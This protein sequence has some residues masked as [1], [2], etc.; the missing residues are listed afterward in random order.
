MTHPRAPKRD[1]PEP[2]KLPDVDDYLTPEQE[3]QLRTSSAWVAWAWQRE[4]GCDDFDC[5]RCRVGRALAVLS[6]GMMDCN[7]AADVL[8][9][10]IP[11]LVQEGQ[12]LEPVPDVA[13]YQEVCQLLIK[14]LDN[15]E[16]CGVN[17]ASAM[18]TPAAPGT[19]IRFN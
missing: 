19:G 8:C 14:S 17:T 9:G 16:Q 1:G 18:G 2:P 15:V 13:R 7:A 10:L 5:V 11:D 12:T 3:R 4:H 6:K